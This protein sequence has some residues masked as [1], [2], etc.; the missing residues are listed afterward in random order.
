MINYFDYDVIFQSFVNIGSLLIVMTKNLFSILNPFLLKTAKF[1]F[2]LFFVIVVSV[3][4]IEFLSIIIKNR[5]DQ[6]E[7]VD[8]ISTLYM[9]D[10]HIMTSLNDG[11]N[12]ETKN[13][14]LVAES[15]YYTFYK[16]KLLNKNN[17]INK[18]ILGFN[19]HNLAHYNDNFVS[20][21]LSSL[22]ADNYFFT[23]PLLEKIKILIFNKKKLIT[24]SK[25]IFQTANNQLKDIVTTR[26][27]LFQGFSNNSGSTKL[28]HLVCKK[29]IKTQ[30]FT[31]NGEI[32]K[33]F[34]NKYSK[35]N[36][37]YLNEIVNYCIDNNIELILFS[38]PISKFYFNL[39]PKPILMKYDNLVNNYNLKHINFNNLLNED[40]LFMPDGDHVS[41]YGA[42]ITTDSLLKVL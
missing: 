13:V 18:V 34:N 14:S 39:I 4:F 33:E 22:F 31:Q 30:F 8:E 20:G 9:G 3:M 23:L 12:K 42:I 21:S 10:S 19:Y 27:C 36:L 1:L 35:F 29:R 24:F 17:N 15:Y 28:N 16:L 2:P 11:T 40:T 38:A 41:N 32:I 26:T 37:N 25:N 7:L 5:C 6:Y